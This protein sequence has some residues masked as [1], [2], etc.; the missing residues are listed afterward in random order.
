MKRSK[1]GDSSHFSLERRVVPVW[2]RQ[3][4]CF[5]RF[6]EE[7][8]MMKSVSVVF[9]VAILLMASVSNAAT[10]RYKGSGPWEAVSDGT[11]NGWQGAMPGSADTARF[12]WGN[13]TVT[14]DYAAPTIDKF[15]MGVDESG[16]LVVNSG[17]VLTS[18]GN[19]KVGNNNVCTGRLTINAGGQVNANGGWLMVAGNSSVTGI[20]NIDGGVLNCA[21]HLWAAT[22]AGSTATIDISNGGVINVGGMIGLGTIDAVNP[23]GGIATLNVNEDGLLA[24][25]NIHAAGTSIQPGSMLNLYGTGQVTLPGNFVGVIGNY[26]AAGLISGNGALGNVIAAYDDINDVTTVT[27]LGFDPN[28]PSVDAG[29]DMITWSGKA[30]TL[31]PNITEGAG[32][33]WTNL[34]YAWSA[35]PNDGVEFDPN[36]YVEG[37]TVTITKATDDPSTVTLTLAV[38]NEGRA[39]PPVQDSMTIDVYDDACLATKAA[40]QAVIDPTDLDENCITAFGDFAVM[41]TTWLD[42]YTLTGPVAK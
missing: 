29:D 32:S 26:A 10:I 11:T 39:L 22:G 9:I 36:A 40:G 5:I 16:G 18:L 23:G 1:D 42:D 30:V 41:A 34:T 2:H 15:Q 17:G 37:P 6:S 8:G 38:N 20:V 35:D 4:G 7:V 28:A 13:N 19:S 31:D 24:L 12:N 21:G 25:A 33:P 27:A 14:L 3:I